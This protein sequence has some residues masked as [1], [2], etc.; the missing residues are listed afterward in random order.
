MYYTIGTAINTPI[1]TKAASV[2]PPLDPAVVQLKVPNFIV[3]IQE[4]T[5]NG[6]IVLECSTEED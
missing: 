3:G 4:F 6:G 5:E 1:L 2:A